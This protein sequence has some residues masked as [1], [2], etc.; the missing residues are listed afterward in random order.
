MTAND[1]AQMAP[2]G[3]GVGETEPFGVLRGLLSGGEFLP[4]QL[5]SVSHWSPELGLAAAVL[6]QAMSDIRLRRADGR[7]H[8]LVSAALRW[9]RS[10]DTTWPMSFLRVCELLQLDVAWVRHA[11]DRWLYRDAA[12]ARSR[13]LRRAA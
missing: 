10:N 11:V 9:V 1:N 2:V 4:S 3:V 13:A 5:P 8:I 12:P 6:V 7:D